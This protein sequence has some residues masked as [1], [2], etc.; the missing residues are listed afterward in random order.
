MNFI[1]GLFPGFFVGS[2]GALM[3][4]ILMMDATMSYKELHRDID[5]NLTVK[6]ITFRKFPNQYKL[7][8]TDW[9]NLSK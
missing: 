3:F 5:N 8:Y 1:N 2:I 4:W 7:D 6:Q 9:E